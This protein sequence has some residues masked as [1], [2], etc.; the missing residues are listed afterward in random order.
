MYSL[1]CVSCPPEADQRS[2][3][4]HALDALADQISQTPT[5]P[6]NQRSE[7]QCEKHAIDLPTKHCAFMNC[8]WSHRTSVDMQS[9]KRDMFMRN[10]DE[11]LVEHLLAEHHAQIDP[12]ASDLQQTSGESEKVCFASAYQEAI[13]VA[14]RRGAPLA[15]Y[16][17][18]RRSLF[19]ASQ[20]LRSD[21]VESLVCFWCSRRFPYRRTA[22]ANEI[23]WHNPAMTVRSSDDAQAVE[24]DFLGVPR[25]DVAKIFGM[26]SYLDKYGQCDPD[27]PD[28]R[29]RPEEFRDFQLDIPFTNGTVKVLC[30]PEDRDCHDDTCRESN[31]CCPRCKIPVCMEC[32]RAKID[33]EGK[34][35]DATSCSR[36]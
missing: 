21:T 3:Q 13:A 35:Q 18:D 6:W 7:A 24:Y 33:R 23:S 27:G 14:I 34:I 2:T 30:C 29:Q 36:Q 19:N 8:S 15:S 22:T 26:D 12:V 9:D 32:D 10:A 28:L 5:L 20:G 17:I 25:E 4:E 31:S 11:K 16:S 1:A